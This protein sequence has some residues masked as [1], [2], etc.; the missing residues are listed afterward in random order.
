[1]LTFV[2]IS[3]PDLSWRD[4]QHV[5]VNSARRAPGIRGAT[6]SPLKRGDWVQN[7]VGLYVSK[8]YG[9]GLMDAERMVSL[10]KD[11]KLVPPQQLRCEIKSTDENK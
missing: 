2:F 8:F 6:G 1:M 4:V 5:I 9:F 7:K 3:R 10:A 11:W